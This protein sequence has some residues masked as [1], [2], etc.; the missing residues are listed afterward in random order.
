MFTAI[1]DTLFPIRCV[2]C[3]VR[4][5]WLCRDCLATLPRKHEQHCPHC[6]VHPTPNGETCLDCSTK[7]ALD[8]V[9]AATHYH[10]PILANALHIFKYKFIHSIAEPLGSIL[11]ES[12][13][14]CDLPLPDA[15]IPV[16]L[17]PRRLRFRGF[18]QS[19]LLATLL[20][21]NLTPGIE[22]PLVSDA[23]VR[24]RHTPP[25]ARID[26]AAMRR[27]NLKNAFAVSKPSR[28]TLKGK[29]IWLVDDVSTTGTTLEECARVLKKS[30]VKKVFGIVVAQ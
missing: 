1:L 3:D 30:G 10:E 12:L 15:I 26:D 13:R 7:T 28:A 4:G 18:N 11:I 19:A 14:H 5:E 20:S 21:R 17:H 16:P 2:G 29:T 6:Q 9:F 23:L 22:L 25:Q 24:I 8:G 27:S